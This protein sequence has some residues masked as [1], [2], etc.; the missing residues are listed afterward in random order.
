MKYVSEILQNS[1]LG[2]TKNVKGFFSKDYWTILYD[3]NKTGFI[4][5]WGSNPQKVHPYLVAPVCGLPT[6]TVARAAAA[7]R[8]RVASKR[9]ACSWHVAAWCCRHLWRTSINA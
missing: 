8:T 9:G 4:L 5:Y 7:S 3:I 6:P 2:S 1:I